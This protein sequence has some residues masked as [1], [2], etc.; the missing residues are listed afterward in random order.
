MLPVSYASYEDRKRRKLKPKHKN[1]C[2]DVLSEFLY[3]YDITL[4]LSIYKQYKKSSI[5]L[6][7]FKNQ[8]TVA[9]IYIY[10]V[11]STYLLNQET[12]QTSLNASLSLFPSQKEQLN[13][14]C[15]TEMAV[16]HNVSKKEMT[17]AV[18]KWEY[19]E[20]TCIYFL[21][22]ANKY[23]GRTL[24]LPHKTKPLTEKVWTVNT[25]HYL[26]WFTSSPPPPPRQCW[27]VL[28]AHYPIP[29]T[30]PQKFGIQKE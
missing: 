10:T 9:H 14:D 22:L 21:L 8:G 1:F 20:T 16:Y 15:I 29:S 19:N 24:R 23:N 11:S 4:M 5:F 30:L 6:R 27:Y 3:W 17:S 2:C 13:A 7:S 25:A 18:K 12:A 28:T 26:H